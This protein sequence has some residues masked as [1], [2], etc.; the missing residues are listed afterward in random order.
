MNREEF[1]AVF[2]IKEEKTIFDSDL[3]KLEAEYDAKCKAFAARLKAI[4]KKCPHPFVKS[5]ITVCDICGAE[6]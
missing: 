5:P 2:R 1:E 3:R 4:Q 6:C